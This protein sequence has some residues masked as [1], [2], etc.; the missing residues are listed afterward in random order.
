[1]S[2]FGKCRRKNEERNAGQ[3]HSDNLTAGIPG[4]SCK[5][6]GHEFLKDAFKTVGFYLFSEF[7]T[8]MV[9]VVKA[10]WKYIKENA[11]QIP[12]NRRKIRVDEK[13][14]TIFNHPLGEPNDSCTIQ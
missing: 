8:W 7:G 3:C 1:M 6:R 11:L 14:G 12:E 13:L 4:R 9:Q 10:L 5:G 2:K